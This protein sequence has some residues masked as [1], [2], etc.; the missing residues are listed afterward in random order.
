MLSFIGPSRF[1]VRA[2]VLGPEI[3]VRGQSSSKKKREAIEA[4]EVRLMDRFTFW[5][6]DVSDMILVSCAPSLHEA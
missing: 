5:L 3:S 4:I 2:S 6:R 1:V